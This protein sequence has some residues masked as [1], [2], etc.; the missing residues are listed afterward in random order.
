MLILKATIYL[1]L[2]HSKTCF[3]QNHPLNITKQDEF[4]TFISVKKWDEQLRTINHPYPRVLMETLTLDT[5][6]SF[7]NDTKNVTDLNISQ[8]NIDSHLV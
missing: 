6:P 4:L 3:K 1:L 8:T 7:G 5:S 2:P